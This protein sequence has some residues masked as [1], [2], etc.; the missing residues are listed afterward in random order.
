L[1]KRPIGQPFPEVYD[2]I[3]LKPRPAWQA[4]YEEVKA[5]LGEIGLAIP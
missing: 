5:E 3:T 4:L 1:D 2:P